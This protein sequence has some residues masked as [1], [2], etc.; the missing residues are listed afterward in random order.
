MEGTYYFL[1]RSK[2][3]LFPKERNVIPD[4]GNNYSV[5]KDYYL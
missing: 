1:A 2:I 4:K 5:K 3:I